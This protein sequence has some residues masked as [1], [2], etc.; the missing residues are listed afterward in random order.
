M[1]LNHKELKSLSLV[2]SLVPVPLDNESEPTILES[3]LKPLVNSSVPITL[4][5]EPKP[6]VLKPKPTVLE[7]W[8]P[9]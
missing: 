6:I 5:N 9:L 2:N 7:P 4:D 1:K 8:S 3:K